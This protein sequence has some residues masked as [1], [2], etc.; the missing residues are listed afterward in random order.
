VT[1]KYDISRRLHIRL[2]IQLNVKFRCGMFTSDDITSLLF[3]AIKMYT[4]EDKDV[5]HRRV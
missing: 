5:A 1:K 4:N 3:N 2:E